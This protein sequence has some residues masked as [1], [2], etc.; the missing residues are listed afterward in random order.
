[1][2]W[3]DGI[4][5]LMDMGLVGLRELVLDREAWLAVVHGVTRSRTRLS[6]W[7]ELIRKWH[8]LFIY[9][10]YDSSSNSKKLKTL[11]HVQLYCH[12]KNV[13]WMN[14]LADEIIT[15]NELRKGR[16]S[17]VYD[18]ILFSEIF[19]QWLAM[20]VVISF[21]RDLLLKKFEGIVT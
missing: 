19:S 10:F 11:F 17:S 1:M 6:D 15:I 13:K 7:T 12:L 16:W 20:S 18:T 2:I 21:T 8:Y 3:F 14:E 9:S 5:D 4:A